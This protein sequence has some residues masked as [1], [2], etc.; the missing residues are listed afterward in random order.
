MNAEFNAQENRTEPEDNFA[1]VTLPPP[2]LT[3]KQFGQRYNKS[4][5]FAYR[6]IYAGRVRV[7]PGVRLVIPISEVI[8]FESETVTYNGRKRRRKGRA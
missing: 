1:A 7:L 4:A 8:K 6:M 2:P 5:S 3:P